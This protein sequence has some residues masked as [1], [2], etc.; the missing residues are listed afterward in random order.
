MAISKINPTTQRLNLQGNKRTNNSAP[1]NKTKIPSNT[2]KTSKS[3]SQI[4]PLLGFLGVIGA[5]IVLS[6]AIR[7]HET[8]RA[9]KEFKLA[10]KEFLEKNNL[11]NRLKEETEEVLS[12]KSGIVD[13]IEVNSSKKAESSYNI[14]NTTSEYDLKRKKQKESEEELL[15]ISNESVRRNKAK[16]ES[17]DQANNFIIIDDLSEP[18]RSAKGSLFDDV[19]DDNYNILA[20]SNY[21]N[22][23]RQSEIHNPFLS[24]EDDLDDVVNDIADYIDDCDCDCGFDFDLF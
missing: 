22:G 18:K 8:S 23:Y 9:R 15:R 11:Q 6:T 20:Y 2:I 16:Q 5:L 19:D 17:L 13:D 24:Y 10:R 7:Y 4:K 21:D 3:N 14:S 1:N 12:S